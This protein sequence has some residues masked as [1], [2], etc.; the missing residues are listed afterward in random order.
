[1]RPDAQ[2]PGAPLLR[3]ATAKLGASG[4][5]NPMQHA[6]IEA[7]TSVSS[8]HMGHMAHAGQTPSTVKPRASPSGPQTD[9]PYTCPMHPQ[10]R[11][12][13]PGNCPICGQF[14]MGPFELGDAIHQLTDDA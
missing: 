8:D 9:L 11:Q 2:T 3:W 10:V 4:W 7:G 6:T 14:L 5:G 13:G 12:M 1:M